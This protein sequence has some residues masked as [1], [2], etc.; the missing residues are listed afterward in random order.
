MMDAQRWQQIKEIFNSALQYEPAQRSAFLVDACNG[1]DSLRNEVESLIAS[2]EKDGGFMDSPAYEVAAGLVVTDEDHLQAGQQLGDYEIVSL[3]GK[4]GMGQVYLAH[5]RRLDRKVALKFLSASF[6]NDADRTRRFEQEARAA[7]ALNQPNILTIYEISEADGRR[8]IATEYIEGETL[9]Q[10]LLARALPPS[11]AL[12]IAEQIASALVAAHAAGIIHRDIKPENVMLRR[13]GIVKVLDFGLAKLSEGKESQPEDSTRA[14]VK[15]SAGTVMGTVAYMSPEQARGLPVDIRTDIWSLGVVLYEMI[16]GQP[17]FI[18]ATTSDVLVAVL[19]RNPP[20]LGNS[21]QVSETLEWI[22]TK[23]LTKDREERYQTAR[24]MLTDIR[25]LKQRLDQTTERER[26]FAPEIVENPH[27]D[28]LSVA[29][30]NAGTNP[31]PA[32]RRIWSRPALWMAIGFLLLIAGA[33]AWNL[34]PSWFKR[35]T[36]SGPP[37]IVL[38]DSPLADRV[39]DPE[40]RKKGG[41]NSDDISDILRDLPVSIEKENTSAFW[42]REDQMLRRNPALIIIHRSSFADADMAFDPQSRATEIA[43]GRVISFVGYIG[44]GDPSTKFLIYTRRP[45]DQGPWLSDLEKRFPQLK[46]RVSIMTVAGGPE[47]ATFRDPATAQA[48]QQQVK[49]ILGLH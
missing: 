20:S 16:S 2:H 44:L 15:T 5:D 29:N 3:L 21:C 39:Y 38:M 17:P 47:H 4:G 37:V 36:P 9:R 40:T 24:E 31:L 34:K 26:S 42:H 18:A 12:I 45:G 14:M 43:D 41:T 22:V 48:V 6:L 8:F 27:A 33:I 23:A 13:D 46:G 32:K 28:S 49:S 19:E 25:R 1:D 7:S 35:A 30:L 10:R 11:E